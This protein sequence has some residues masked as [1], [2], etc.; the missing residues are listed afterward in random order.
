MYSGELDLFKTIVGA[1]FLIVGGHVGDRVKLFD[2]KC[3]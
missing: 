1:P 2:K 3:A